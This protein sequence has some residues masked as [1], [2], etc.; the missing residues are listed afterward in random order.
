MAI[1]SIGS[2]IVGAVAAI[3]LPVALFLLVLVAGLVGMLLVVFAQHLSAW[4]WVRAM[5][6]A[7]CATQL[8]YVVGLLA[9]ARLARTTP[10]SGLAQSIRAR[11]V[12]RR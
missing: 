9:Q 11:M 12:S 2:F 6:F 10:R 3:F 8:G 5:I 4:V 7:L 1:F